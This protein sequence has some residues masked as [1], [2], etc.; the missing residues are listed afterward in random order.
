MKLV[1]IAYLDKMTEVL[2]AEQ[3][4]EVMTL[5]LSFA[6]P[7]KRFVSLHHQIQSDPTYYKDKTR[8]SSTFS[9]Y[10]SNLLFSTFHNFFPLHF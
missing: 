8:I 6:M 5:L 1:Y 3:R 2:I 9:F 10:N 7:G 4:P